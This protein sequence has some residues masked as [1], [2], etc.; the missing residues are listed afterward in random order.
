MEG[1]RY[2]GKAIGSESLKEMHV[3]KKVDEWINDIEQISEIV[4]IEP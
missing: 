2:L 4:K 1:G 3:R